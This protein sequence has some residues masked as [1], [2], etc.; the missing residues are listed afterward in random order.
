MQTVVV[1]S[2]CKVARPLKLARPAGGQISHL[3]ALCPLISTHPHEH[4]SEGE[5]RDTETKGQ[6]WPTTRLMEVLLMSSLCLAW[7]RQF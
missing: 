3:C 1:E 4:R 5:L 7:K 2:T 6:F